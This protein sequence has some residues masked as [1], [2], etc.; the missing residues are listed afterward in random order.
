MACGEFGPGRMAEPLAI[1]AAIESGARDRRR[2]I[3]LARRSPT[4]AR[5]R[6]QA[7]MSSSPP[8]PTFEAIDPVR[9]IGNRSSGLQGFAIAEAAATRAHGSPWSP[10][11]S[12]SPIRADVET[13][14]VESA[15]EML[16]AVEAALPAD[17]FVSAAAVADWRVATPAAQKLKK[18]A[19]G[20]PTL[21]LVENPDIL[22]DNRKV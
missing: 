1:V 11:R 16:A 19:G 2:R 5:R 15:R 10:G 18:G 3:P 21:A 22:A 4:P 12:R 17:V 6:S 14:R 20:P 13:V 9:F 8:G 7:G